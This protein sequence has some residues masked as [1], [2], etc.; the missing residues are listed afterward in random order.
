MGILDQIDDGFG[1]SV[2][3]AD[4]LQ[5]KDGVREEKTNRLVLLKHK[6]FELC[7]TGST[8]QSCFMVGF[9]DSENLD[10]W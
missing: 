5:A 7:L 8:D 2:S 10:F 4:I 9:S 1:R 6:C 3:R